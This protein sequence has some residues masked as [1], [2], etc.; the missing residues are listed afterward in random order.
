MRRATRR[1][2]LALLYRDAGAVAA[3]AV[4]SAHVLGYGAGLW[5]PR[6]PV[7]DAVDILFAAGFADGLVAALDLACTAEAAALAERVS[8]CERHDGV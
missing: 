4:V 1:R 5:R 2:S 8:G 7:V 3:G 6:V